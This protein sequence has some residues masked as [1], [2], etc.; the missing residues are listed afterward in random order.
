MV[1]CAYF[2]VAK[3]EHDR[4]VALASIDPVYDSDIVAGMFGLVALFNVFMGA[5]GVLLMVWLVVALGQVGY[6]VLSRTR[7]SRG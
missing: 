6:R 1:W 5:V 2:W 3:I 7:M 4:V